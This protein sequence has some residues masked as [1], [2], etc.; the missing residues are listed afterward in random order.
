MVII[1]IKLN[2]FNQ[3]RFTEDFYF[4]SDPRRFAASDTHNAWHCEFGIKQVSAIYV[5]VMRYDYIIY[6]S[7]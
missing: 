4:A 3:I 1:F 5:I 6:T 7:L 2:D